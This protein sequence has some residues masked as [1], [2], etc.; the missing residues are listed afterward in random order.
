[1]AMAQ[2]STQTPSLACLLKWVLG[3]R[4]LLGRVVGK[5]DTL[6]DVALEALNGLGQQALLLL[7][8]AL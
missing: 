4:L 2:G 6:S 8:E 3:V 7:G 5:V 1:M